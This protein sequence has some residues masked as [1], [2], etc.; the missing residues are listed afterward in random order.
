[1]KT[2]PKFIPVTREVQFANTMAIESR[3]LW[4]VEGD[5][6]GGPFLSYTFKDIDNR[7]LIVVE[8]FSYSPGAKKRDFVFELEAILKTVKL[9]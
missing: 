6:M 3:G 7:R 9:D 1:M 5:F 2:E 8:G 4:F